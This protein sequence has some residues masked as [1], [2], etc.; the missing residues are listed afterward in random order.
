[1][2]QGKVLIRLPR[3]TYVEDLGREV[4]LG[5]F[6]KHVIRNP[7]RSFSDKKNTFKPEELQQEPHRFVRRKD[8]YI[9]MDADFLD[10]YK[11]LRRLAQIITLKDLGRI[12]TLLGVNDGSVVVEAGSGSGAATAYLS[13]LARKVHSYEVSDDHLAVAKENVKALGRDNVEFHRQDVYED[14]EEHGADAFLLDVP[15]PARAL[16][17]VSKALRVGG[18]CVVYTP[19]LTQAQQAVASLPDDF[20]YEGTS[21]LTE[22]QWEVRDK[23]LRPRMQGLGHTAF[24]TLIRKLPEKGGEQ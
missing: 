12:V 11:Q 4:S 3:K 7:G 10:E 16:P 8:D 6:E 9:L 14:V 1:M 2:T 22:R 18:R 19:N 23:V 24:L 15:D 21:E 13:R 17:Q 5:S 20:L